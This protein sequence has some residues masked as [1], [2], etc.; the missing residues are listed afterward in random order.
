MSTPTTSGWSCNDFWRTGSSSRQRSECST[1]PPRSSWATSWRRGRSGR[2]PI[3]YGRWRSGRDPPIK[4]SYGASLG[5][6]ISTAGSSEARSPPLRPDIDPPSLLLDPGGQGRLLNPEEPVHLGPGAHPS[7]SLA[8]VHRR[9]GCLGCG[10]RCRPLPAVG[11][12]PAHPPS[13][14][15]VPPFLTGSGK[16]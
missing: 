11:G 16:L 4:P 10:H 2:T 3:R 7:S 15:P 6:P 5:S 12:G 13:R 14:L 9:G 1:L 8:L